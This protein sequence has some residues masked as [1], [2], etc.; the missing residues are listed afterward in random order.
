[1][2]LTK[3]SGLPRTLPALLG[4]LALVL[5]L[6]LGGFAHA[7]AHA[8]AGLSTSSAAGA[9][10]AS[11]SGATTV[12]VSG[13][14]YQSIK[15]GFGGIYV[16]FGYVASSGWK[17][18]Q[19]GKAG[20][21][22][23]YIAD[24]QAKDNKGYQKFVAYPGSS[25]ADSANGGTI[26]ANGSFSAKLVIPGPTFSA[27]TSAGGSKSIDCREVTCGI[28]TFG[29]H[30]VSNGANEAFTPISFGAAASDTQQSQQGAASQAPATQGTTN[31]GK[32]TTTTTETQQQGAGQ[33]PVEGQAP[34][35]GTAEQNTQPDSAQ[36]GTAAGPKEA[37]TSGDPTL[38]LE[39]Q[40]V[41]A[42]RSLGFTGRGFAAGE[43]VVATLSSGL[44]AA[45]PVTAGQFGEI[46]GAV[47]IPA[48]TTAG[49]HQI[50]L[51]GAGSGNSVQAEFSVMADAA[52]LAAPATDSQP[53]RWALIAVVV[54]G[55]LL[56]VLIIS[57]LITALMRRKKP[58]KRR[59]A[60]AR[61]RKVRKPVARRDSL[62]ASAPV[63]RSAEADPETSALEQLD[64]SMERQSV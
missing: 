59:P 6:I 14:G 26:A 30:G 40:T 43:Q 28:F 50:K 7:P 1:M 56:L 42:G 9:G 55:A 12:T 49:T 17:P 53:I 21:D 39:Q 52:A 15:N 29:A 3:S 8:A 54:T 63:A 31:S 13:R 38:G 62:A 61:R 64:D 58:A 45:G 48:E 36:S 60:Q 2:N 18:S 22:F 5:L 11:A 46:A 23:F 41:I 10:K 25:T 27:A 44:T 34:V 24:T 20:K 37:V 35:A 51:T 19:G 16:V 57:S 33:S 4:T 47:Q 32:S